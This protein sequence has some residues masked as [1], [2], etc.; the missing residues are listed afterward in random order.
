MLAKSIVPEI[1]PRLHNKNATLKTHPL[2][3][4]GQDAV[5]SAVQWAGS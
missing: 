2:H 1:V 5:L 3:S 4:M